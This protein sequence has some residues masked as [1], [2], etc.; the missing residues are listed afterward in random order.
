MTSSGDQGLQDWRA[1]VRERFA[2]FVKAYEGLD[3]EALRD[4]FWHDDDV[5]LLGT[6]AN[7]HFLGW[8]QLEHS[9]RSQC[10]LLRDLQITL[11]SEP[12]V[13]GGA[14][15]STMACLSLAAMDF[16]M[17]ADGKRVAFTGI[18]VSC[19]FERRESSWKLVQMHWS[20]P[21]EDVLVDHG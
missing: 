10:E 7:L 21:R 18:R 2:A 20:L 6:H 17:T 3:F 1:E 5:V 12:V 19:A 16:S 13:H 14:A 15:P 9:L 11:R 4:L 8:H